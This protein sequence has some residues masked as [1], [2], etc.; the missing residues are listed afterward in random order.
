MAAVV[1]SMPTDS[2]YKFIALFGL[3]VLVFGFYF[4]N[5]KQLQIM[6][7]VREAQKARELAQIKLRRN[8]SQS[9]ALVAEISAKR[10]ALSEKQKLV[11]EA[12][13]Q[14]HAKRQA[15]DKQLSE[16]N[17]TVTAADLKEAQSRITALTLETKALSE[18][19]KEL[20][21][22]ARKLSDDIKPVRVKQEEVSDEIAAANVNLK[23]D[24]EALEVQLVMMKWWLLV[25]CVSILAG[26]VMIFVGFRLWYRRIQIHQDA[27]LRDQA[28]RSE[29]QRAESKLIKSD[30]AGDTVERTSL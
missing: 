14:I 3:V 12:Q 27:I 10:A 20:A 17:A 8:L 2:V 16:M 15:L 5:E 26:I 23:A 11:E 22:D 9:D 28:Q 24:K 7:N 4:P 19:A 29:A 6:K 13:T 1:P 18:Q 30:K 25:M 21:E